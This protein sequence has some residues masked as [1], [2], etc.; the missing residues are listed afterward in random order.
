VEERWR[1]YLK[2][3]GFPELVPFVQA[4]ARRPE[5]R[6]L[7]PYTSLNRF[8]FSRCTG[9]PFTRDTPLVQPVENGEYE[10]VLEDVVL[11]RGN[12]EQAAKLVVAHL[13]PGCGP[14]VPGTAD[15]LEKP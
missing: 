14:A 5:L 11:G 13:P 8:C 15:D 10:V 3:F 2:D 7:F 1:T 12:A 9:Y 4:A 6:Q